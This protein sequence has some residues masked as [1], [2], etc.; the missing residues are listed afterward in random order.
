MLQLDLVYFCLLCRLFRKLPATDSSNKS[1][2]LSHLLVA[3]FRARGEKF[4]AENPMFLRVLRRLVHRFCQ[5]VEV[6]IEVKMTSTCPKLPPGKVPAG[7]AHPH[8]KSSRLRGNKSLQ[9][10]LVEQFQ[11]KSCGFVT[12][13]HM[14]LHEVGVKDSRAFSSRTTAEYCCRLLAKNLEFLS[15]YQERCDWKTLN[16]CF[17]LASVSHEYVIQH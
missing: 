3:L 14:S 16:V 8:S 11:T 6:A 2:C 13:K 10:A 9:V 17:D 7:M 5:A 12:S 15:K 1:V 4:Y